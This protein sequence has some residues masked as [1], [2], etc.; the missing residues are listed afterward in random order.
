MKK[1]FVSIFLVFTTLCAFAQSNDYAPQMAKSSIQNKNAKY[2]IFPTKNINVFLKLD[3]STG[4]IWM[5]HIALGKGFPIAIKFPESEYP[6]ILDEE[7]ENGRFMLYPTQNIYNFLLIDQIDG[8]VWQAQW[9][10]DSEN[11]GIVR[12]Y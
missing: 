8:R 1:L 7:K 6:L 10:F 3:T 12:I 9:S 2:L 11:T 5:I 4:E